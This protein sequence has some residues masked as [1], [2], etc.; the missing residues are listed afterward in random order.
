MESEGSDNDSLMQVDEAELIEE[1]DALEWH[2]KSCTAPVEKTNVHAASALC[3]ACR[4]LLSGS[5]DF[6]TYYKHYYYLSS[7]RTAADRGCYLCSQARNKIDKE[8]QNH[9][10]LK[11]LRLIAEIYPTSEKSDDLDRIAIEGHQIER[12]SQSLANCVLANAWLSTCT[13]EHKKCNVLHT[14]QDWSPTRLINV[15]GVRSGDE[16]ISL[17]Q[18]KDRLSHL[19][20]MTLSHCWGSQPFLKL[21]QSNLRQLQEYIPIS[22]LPKTFQDAVMVT[23]I[24]FQCDYLWIDSLCIIQDSAED[25][26]NESAEMRHIYKSA[27]LNIAATGAKDSSYGL[28]FNRDP[29]L[30]SSGLAL[31][32][33]EADMPKGACR[34][35]SSDLWADGVSRAPVNR[36]A[37]VVQERVLARRNLHFGS[38]SLFFECHELEACETF[39]SGVPNYSN[40]LLDNGFKVVSKHDPGEDEAAIA[41]F[42]RSWQKIS[43][44]YMNCAL[45]FA[46]D[47]MIALSG[48][49]D[50][51]RSVCNKPYVAGLF[52]N[53]FLIEQL[54]W[55]RTGGQQMSGQPATR[56]SV[57][58]APSWSWLSLDAR[59]S[60][61]VMFESSQIEI[62]QVKIDLINERNPTGP[63]RQGIL[64]I[65]GQLKLIYLQATSGAR[66]GFDVTDEVGA[67]IGRM[68]VNFDTESDKEIQ[69]YCMPVRMIPG[70]MLEGL[71]LLPSKR[72]HTELTRVAYFDSK[73]T[74]LIEH[75]AQTQA[76]ETVDFK[77]V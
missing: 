61:P 2:D 75:L 73:D 62:L 46:S 41:P 55:Q 34:F 9:Q 24:W 31:V 38:Q 37:W 42:L 47:K 56:S 7:L 76:V 14:L 28:F 5:K 52:D 8:T 51:F 58:R 11:V 10:P 40:R 65:R 53:G 32:D 66:K 77:I 71:L 45:T 18:G 25:W 3:H 74:G 29:S 68:R 33:W 50:E 49:A 60:C 54:M 17:V 20:Y 21:T 39:P 16:K 27:W 57:Y 23:A 12:S 4:D 1:Y 69:V 48:V 30:V 72:S 6:Q 36:R 19:R 64:S 67:R 26:Q 63:V 59:I 35:F 22:K 43:T 13:T 70:D 44:K 15:R